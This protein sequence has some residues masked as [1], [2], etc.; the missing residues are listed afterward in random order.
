MVFN[1]E[2][3]MPFPGIDALRWGP[4]FDAG[5]V[6]PDGKLASGVYDQGPIRMSTGVA[7]I[8]MSPFGP[9]KFAIAKALNS[10]DHDKLQTFQ[11]Q[12][13]QTF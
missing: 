6:Y 7:A 1:S 8:W 3:I 9:L 2:L 10:Q 12:M 4:F 11:F 13:G 5:Q